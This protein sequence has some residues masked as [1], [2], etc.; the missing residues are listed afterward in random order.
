M[1]EVNHPVN[2]PYIDLPFFATLSLAALIVRSSA[3][4]LY[5]KARPHGVCVLLVGT[6]VYLCT[7]Q[8][9]EI[10]WDQSLL[11]LSENPNDQRADICQCKAIYLI[12]S[13][14]QACSAFCSSTV[15]SR[16]SS[17]RNVIVQ[18]VHI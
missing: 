9:S 1:Q 2:S 12:Y 6:R 13:S 4:S 3:L 8:T 7:H 10:S 11:M 18:F 17:L 14:N 16:F 5:S 15:Q